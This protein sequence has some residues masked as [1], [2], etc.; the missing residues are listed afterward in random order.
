MSKTTTVFILV[1]AALALV[2]F[3]KESKTDLARNVLKKD[4]EI[5]AFGDS[6]TYGFG[7]SSASSYPVLLEKKSG[8]HVTNAGINGE[9]SSEGLVRL[10]Q[11]LKNRP[12]LVILCHGGNDILRK[13]SE[14]ELKSNLIAMIDLIKQSGAEVLLVGVPDFNMFGFGTHS[15]YYEVA[16]L[17]DVMFEDEVLSYI[18]LHRELKSDYVHPNA[19]GYERMAEAFMEVLK[20]NKM[21]P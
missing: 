21:I 4:A 8:F 16:K 15:V 3:L 11:M 14:E 12:D 2:I 9:E 19:K 13:L 10:A 7:A 5:L 17:R 18:E 1:L 6:L 20:K